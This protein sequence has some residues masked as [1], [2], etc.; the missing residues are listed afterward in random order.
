MK[1]V[2]AARNLQRSGGRVWVSLF[3]IAFATFL[4][5]IQGSLLYSFVRAAS[6]V[7]DSIDADL[8]IISKGTPTFDYVSPIPER[9]ADL[10]L[11][12]AGIRDAGRGIA[13][14]ASIRRPDGDSNLVM[15]IGV[16]KKYQGRLP[17]IAKIADRSGYSDFAVVLDASDATRLGYDR[18][19]REVQISGRRGYYLAETNGFAS[20]IGSPLIFTSYVDAHQY[21][22][23]ERTQASFIALHVVPGYRPAVVRDALRSRFPD[24][25][26]WTS[27]ELSWRSRLFWLAQTGA[28]GA[29]TVA[30]VLGFGIGLVLVAQAIY[31]ITAENIDEFATMKAMGASDRDVHTVVLVQSFI[32]GIVGGVFGLSGVEPFTTLLRVMVSWISVPLWMYLVVVGALA[33][34]CVL[35]SLIAA[36]PAL[37]V[38]PARVFR[39]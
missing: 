21:L 15:V 3:G 32:C 6:R 31:G 39:A 25:D 5:C 12:I 1:L 36:R 4:M 29:L 23:L 8:W 9:Y 26:V 30:A 11:G 27:S 34:L 33:L 17:D 10:A 37:Q 19:L 16:E 28:G 20:F 24:V 2:L 14:W 22:R 18:S 38:E 7:V 13:G 35:A